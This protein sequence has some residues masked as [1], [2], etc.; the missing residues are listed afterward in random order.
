MTGLHP[1]V[2]GK[3]GEFSP[4]TSGDP[5]MALCGQW[6]GLLIRA[7]PGEFLADPRNAREPS[8]AESEA[9]DRWL[10]SLGEKIT[11]TQPATPAAAL[12]KLRVTQQIVQDYCEDKIYDELAAALNELEQALASAGLLEKDGDTLAELSRIVSARARERAA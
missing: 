11:Q 8:H 3:G 4:P 5:L 6:A 7:F 2:D 9:F 1:S 10:W 12:A